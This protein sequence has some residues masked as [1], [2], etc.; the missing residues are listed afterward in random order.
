DWEVSITSS[1]AWL[2]IASIRQTS[3]RLARL[4]SSNT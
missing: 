1:E 4:S 3:R 2:L